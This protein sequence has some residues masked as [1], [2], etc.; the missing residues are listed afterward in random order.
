MEGVTLT[1]GLPP[2][3]SPWP[4]VAA[5]PAY[6]SLDMGVEGLTNRDFG[7]EGSEDEEL[8]EFLG[9]SLGDLCCSVVSFGF[10]LSPEV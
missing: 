4:M 3:F 9:K 5:P 7:G 1:T 2:V 8:L 6:K 10:L